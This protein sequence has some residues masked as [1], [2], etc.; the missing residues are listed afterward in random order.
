VSPVGVAAEALVEAVYR[1]LDLFGGERDLLDWAKTL[2]SDG[3][4]KDV[5]P[6]Y[7][8][9]GSVAA[10]Q[11]ALVECGV[12][13]DDA[14]I[15]RVR[16]LQFQ[17]AV[18]LLPH[19]RLRENA[20]VLPPA[21]KIV[22]TVPTVVE[23]ETD[24]AHLQ[25]SIAA[26]LNTLLATSEDRVLIAAPYWSHQGTELLRDGTARACELGHKIVLAGARAGDSNGHDHL[27]AMRHFAQR[28]DE[29]G[30]KVR[31]LEWCDPDPTSIFHAKLVCCEEGYLGSGNFTA[32]AMRTHVE[33]GTVLTPAEVQ[34]VWWLIEVLEGAGLL[35][36]VQRAR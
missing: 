34:R 36:E 14:T 35:R 6:A 5:A 33:A 7:F 8:G 15:D 16:M 19:F 20:R 12:I 28:L 13:R 18:E 23:L 21:P 11:R 31:C 3:T 22:F 24:R 10:L 32:A 27:L 2:D 4:A 26:R 30:A 17:E 1:A 29:A 9:R 25:R